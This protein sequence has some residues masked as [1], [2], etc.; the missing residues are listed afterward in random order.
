[1][2]KR[3]RDDMTTLEPGQYKYPFSIRLPEVLPPTLHP[4]D[5]PFVRYE[6]QVDLII[7]KRIFYLNF[8]FSKAFN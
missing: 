6:L 3:C 8:T 7:K 4:E 2:N 5:Y 1:M